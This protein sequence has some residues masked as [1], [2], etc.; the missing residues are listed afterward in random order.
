LNTKLQQIF[1]SLETQRNQL[2]I[3]LN[4]L[5]V[6][7][8]NQQPTNG[9]SINQVIAHLIAAERLSVLYLRK[10]IQAINEVENTGLI[11]ELKMIVIILSQRLPFKF[12]APKTVVENT[13]SST[14]IHQ[15]EQ[16]WNAVRNEL[17]IVL[18]KF[19]DD[20]IK[21]KIYKHVVAGKLNIQ[22]TL[23]FFREHIIH[24]QQQIKRLL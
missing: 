1:D 19:N 21:R 16:E 6:E 9:W 4:S 15:L 13:K 17:K 7:K 22:Q 3:S 14:S 24:H 12:K 18:E 2:F 8:L 23:L 5:A 20:Q 11:E 10:K